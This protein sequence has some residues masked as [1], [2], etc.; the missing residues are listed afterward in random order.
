[1]SGIDIIFC[2]WNRPEYTAESLRMLAENTHW[3][4]VRRLIIYTD[5]ELMREGYIGRPPI[6]LRVLQY[7]CERHGGPVAIMNHYLQ[8]RPSH[9]FVKLDNDVVVPPDWLPDCEE[10]MH[11]NPEVGLLGIEPKHPPVMSY[12]LGSV[13]RT[14]E[15]CGHIGGIGMMRAS[16]FEGRPLPVAAGRLGFSDWQVKNP[17]VVKAWIRPALPVILLD[18]LPFDPWLSLGREYERKG[19]QRPWKHYGPEDSAIWDWWRK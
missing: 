14:G 19:W 3:G 18:R 9:L 7:N 17:D 6:P 15:T 4:M 11:E 1:M 5:G 8:S 16:A 13:E 12:Q 10:I 2:A